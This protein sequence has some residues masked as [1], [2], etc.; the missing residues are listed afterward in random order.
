[1]GILEEQEDIPGS[2]NGMSNTTDARNDGPGAGEQMGV[3]GAWGVWGV[4]TGGEVAGG[5]AA[6]R[7]NEF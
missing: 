1:M 2:R 7:R 4:V 5:Q 6:V 3:A